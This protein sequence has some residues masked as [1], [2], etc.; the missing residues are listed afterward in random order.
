MLADY[1]AGATETLILLPKKNGKSTMLAALALYHLI[2]TPDA[3]CIIAAASRDQATILY[4]QASGFVRRSPGLQLRVTVKR[5]YREIQS[6]RDSGR[7]RVLAADADTADGV[8]PTL[9]LVD[10]LHRHKSAELY[11][12]FRDGLGPRDGQMV[13]ISTAGDDE[14]GPLG[15]MRHDARDLPGCRTVDCHTYAR[16]RNGAFVMHEWALAS[17][18]DRDDMTIVK[19]A[20]PASWQTVEALRRRHDSPSMTSWAW[21]RF[22]CGVWLAGESAAIAP[23][24][25]DVL[26]EPGIRIPERS[27]VYVGLDLGWKIDCTGIVPLHWESETRRVVSDSLILEPPSDGSLLDER[28]IVDRL[29]WLNARFKLV[30]IVYDPNAGGQQMVQQ[31]EREYGLPFT[32]HSQDNSP[33]ALADSRFMEAI[34]RRAIV[35]DGDRALRQHVLNAIE[36]PLGG[37]KFKFDRPR[38]GPRRPNDG[39]RALSIAHSV[40]VAAFEAPPAPPARVHFL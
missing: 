36:K 18:D 15:L 3:E 39:L 32:E 38:R 12:V 19:R 1:F 11:G 31:L 30:A 16:S 23:H 10:E 37:E 9:A 17:G 35:H 28:L 34:R 40:A 24:E 2:S 33:I 4:D 5:G 7:I 22:G 29:L 25:W 20:N 8:I 21:A 14:T 6:I 13:T 26:E 27:P